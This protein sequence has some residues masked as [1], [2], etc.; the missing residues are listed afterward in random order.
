MAGHSK[1]KQIRHKKAITDAK[2][3]Q[4][5]SKMVREIMVA[6]SAGGPS[7]ETN[8]RLKTAY[9]RSR[10]NGLPRDN[11]ERAIKR[12]SGGGGEKFQEFL[13]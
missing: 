1:W 3:A 6:V 10:E 2:R 12:A 11:I 5:F 4:F 8:T 7:L 9:E 13:F